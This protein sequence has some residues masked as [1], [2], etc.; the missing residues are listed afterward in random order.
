M[1]FALSGFALESTVAS[2]TLAR[3]ASNEA[4]TK[5]SLEWLSEDIWLL[6]EPPESLALSASLFEVIAN[7]S[8]GL[9]I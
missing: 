5:A 2:T 7:L 4:G 3:D 8:K 9:M 6:R 1:A